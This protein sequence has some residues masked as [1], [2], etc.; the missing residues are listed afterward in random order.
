MKI[1]L[2]NL[3]SNAI[4][5]TR[6]SKPAVIEFGYQGDEG[7]EFYFLGDNGI[8][9]DLNYAEKLFTPFRRLHSPE[10]YEG[11]GIGL[12]IVERIIKHHNGQIWVDSEV[13]KGTTFYFNI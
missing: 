12:A 5:F 10:D 13:G 4:K 9:F 3:I 7:D 1:L 8:G 2:T 6:E 11:N